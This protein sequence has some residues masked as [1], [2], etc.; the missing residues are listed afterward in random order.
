M[1][2]EKLSR[3]VVLD[4]TVLKKIIDAQRTLGHKIVVTIGSWDLLHIGHTR[5]L[6]KHPT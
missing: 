2:R 4:Y 1:Q 6:W 5:Y 3:K